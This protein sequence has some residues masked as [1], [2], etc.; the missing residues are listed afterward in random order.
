M[1]QLSIFTS[2]SFISGS[3]NNTILHK[4]MTGIYIFLTEIQME[5]V[6]KSNIINNNKTTAKYN[7]KM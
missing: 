5:K 2:F 1:Q 4:L 6:L 3:M 7:A